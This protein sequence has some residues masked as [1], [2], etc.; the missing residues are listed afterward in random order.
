MESISFGV[1]SD[2][3][4][5]LICSPFELKREM[6]APK[7]LI[8]VAAELKKLDWDVDLVDQEGMKSPDPLL[9]YEEKLKI[10]RA[11]V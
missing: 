5:L 9:P 10:G 8:E 6:G 1:M 2:K 3:L 4:K 7:V 11:H